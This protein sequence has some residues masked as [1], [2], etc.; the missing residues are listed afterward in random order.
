MIA[1]RVKPRLNICIVAVIFIAVFTSSIFCLIG[2]GDTASEA[3]VGA[4]DDIILRDVD[5]VYD[6]LWHSVVVDN[7]ADGDEVLFSA[8]A[9]GEFIPER[10][11]YKYPGEYVIYCKVNRSG[12]EVF[13]GSARVTIR[14][15]I[16]AGIDA[17]PIVVVFDGNE[18]G[19]VITGLEDGDCVEYSLD[20]ESFSAV[21]PKFAGVGEYRVY[22]RV[23][24]IYGECR[25]STTV[26]ILPDLS[27]VYVDLRQGAV[28]LCGLTAAVNGAEFAMSYGVDG[29]GTIGDAEFSV[30]G[31]TLYF[32]GAA[33][34]KIGGD[35]K[36]YVLSVS[37]VGFYLHS[38]HAPTVEI[39]TDGGAAVVTVGG[40]EIVTVDDVNYCE[41][42][43]AEDYAERSFAKTL[44]EGETTLELTKRQTRTL[45]RKEIFHIYDGTPVDPDVE[46]DAVL[47][48]TANGFS[49]ECPR[50]SEV[51]E[52]EIEAVVL[53]DEYLPTVWLIGVTIAPNID[54]IYYNDTDAVEIAGA[55][56]WLNGEELR[57]EYDKAWSIAGQAVLPTDDGITLGGESLTRYAAG[58]VVVVKVAESRYVFQTFDNDVKIEWTTAATV[59]FINET[60]YLATSATDKTVTVNDKASPVIHGAE[61]S[62]CIIGLG[63]FDCAIVLIR[64]GA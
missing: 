15:T 51:G 26:A 60:Q 21:A 33:Y 2:C 48:K 7:V 41:N 34:E 58:H 20:G 13:S 35:E 4:A 16:L 27:G 12:I 10:P 39:F 63:D 8:S 56:A 49:E 47:F 50:L 32:D 59:I 6:E 61:K 1:A 22:Y 42:A 11:Q 38:S 44:T 37:G 24:R 17:E 62:F 53:S 45:P 40:K 30:D 19:I 9:D 64:I 52:Y 46:Y 43:D 31:E 36:V 5:V 18:H 54:G 57:A 14:S 25:A 28:T 55:T 23:E 3:L 29:C